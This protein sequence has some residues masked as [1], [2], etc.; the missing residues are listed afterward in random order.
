MSKEY[1]AIRIL[2][3]QNLGDNLARCWRTM[4]KM[5]Y[6]QMCEPWAATT[7]SA[8]EVLAEYIRAQC[9]WRD[10]IKW[11]DA[12]EKAMREKGEQQ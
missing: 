1:T 6:L 3:E 4:Q 12:V 7:K 5:D 9:D 2:I 8:F 10:C 11:L